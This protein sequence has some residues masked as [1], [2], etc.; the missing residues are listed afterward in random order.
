M[1]KHS[2]NRPSVAII[3]AISALLV[4]SIASSAFAARGGSGNGNGDGS[5]GSQS[6]N[7]SAVWLVDSGDW[8]CT[9]SSPNTNDNY[10]TDDQPYVWVKS[11][12]AGFDPATLNWKAYDG[13]NKEVAS[14][15]TLYNHGVMCGTSY[16]MQ[17]YTGIT[18][19]GSVTVKF[20][21]SDGS[22][23]SSDTARFE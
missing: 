19:T 8:T 7:G 20:F 17:P 22:A 18:A 23:F 4:A 5:S 13:K 3:A 2:S 10:I 11:T 12:N 15:N 21:Y 14:G 6:Q 16:L 9:A 1:R